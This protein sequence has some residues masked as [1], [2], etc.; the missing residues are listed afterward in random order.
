MNKILLSL[1]CLLIF[2]SM[3]QSAPINCARGSKEILSEDAEETLDMEILNES[4]CDDHNV[5]ELNCGIY[6]PGCTKTTYFNL[7]PLIPKYPTPTQGQQGYEEYQAYS[8]VCTQKKFSDYSE[9]NAAV[10]KIFNKYVSLYFGNYISWESLNNIL[11]SPQGDWDSR[12]EA[13]W[14]S[15]N[16]NFEQKIIA[17]GLHKLAVALRNFKKVCPQ[18]NVTLQTLLA[19]FN[20]FDQKY[21]QDMLRSTE[22]DL[23][24]N[25]G[26]KSY[27]LLMEVFNNRNYFSSNIPYQHYLMTYWYNQYFYYRNYYAWT[28]YLQAKQQYDYLV[29]NSNAWETVLNKFFYFKS[30]IITEVMNLYLN[31]KFQQDG[32]NYCQCYDFFRFSSWNDATPSW[33]SYSLYG[34]RQSVVK[35]NFVG[36]YLPQ[37]QQQCRK[38]CYGY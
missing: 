3:V 5:C 13:L 25:P 38:K 12:Y 20:E 16:L 32:G 8:L 26:L 35:S 15:L 24:S 2:A 9:S 21:W 22:R 29:Y 27:K 36:K 37:M 18:Q 23:Q 17:Q 28:P 30:L 4:P 33:Y 6:Y 19:K 11:H 34:I 31:P 1:L 14:N 10:Y 7:D